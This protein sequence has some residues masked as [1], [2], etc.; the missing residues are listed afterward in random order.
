MA[1]EGT[2][3]VRK[4]DA[5]KGVGGQLD[6]VARVQ[7]DQDGESDP[8]GDSDDL[9]GQLL[10]PLALTHVQS[11]DRDEGDDPDGEGLLIQQLQFVRSLDQHPPE[12]RVFERV[13]QNEGQ[14]LND[15]EE[16]D[17]C[18]HPFD[19]TGREDRGVAGELEAR[20]QDENRSGQTDGG[21]EQGIP[22]YAVVVAQEKGASEECR[23][24][25]G[26][27]SCDG[28]IRSSHDGHDHACHN[29]RDQARDGWPS[30]SDRDST[31]KREVDHADDEACWKIAPPMDK[32]LQAADAR[33]FFLHT[34]PL[35]LRTGCRPVRAQRI[36]CA[37]HYVHSLSCLSKKEILR[38]FPTTIKIRRYGT[39]IY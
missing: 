33:D 5:L 1:R 29:G 37:E 4:R 34:S 21:E 9:W 13:A 22:D 6:Q 30:G 24:E 25:S 28:H 17:G 32:S 12:G 39:C 3:E 38:T 36:F 18:Q 14:L 26:G 16:T 10:F 8:D 11:E 31:G 27:R 15:N 7:I 35:V 20:Q 19:D 23:S 2:V